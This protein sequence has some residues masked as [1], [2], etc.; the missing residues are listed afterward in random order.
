MTSLETARLVLREFRERDWQAVHEY[1]SDPEVVR[2]VEW[3]PNTETETRSFVRRAISHQDEQPEMVKH[4]AVV[5]V[6]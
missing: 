4:P 3:G 6:S 2:Y 5:K 1:A